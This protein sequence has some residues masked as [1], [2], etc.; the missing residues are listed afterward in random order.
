M[1]V[2]LLRHGIAEEP[3]PGESD[4]DRELTPE[5]R[6]K[7]RDNLRI[8]AEAGAEPTLIL[9]SPLVRALQSAEL[10]G[11]VL[12]YKQEIL[13]TDNLANRCP[14]PQFAA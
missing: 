9:S 2:Y 13:Q 6:T 1:Q 14:A 5:G 3:A 7:L 11:Q 8:A 12:R 10:A 4:A